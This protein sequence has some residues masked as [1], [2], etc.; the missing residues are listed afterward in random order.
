[1]EKR[2]ALINIIKR[3]KSTIDKY[4]MLKSGD[5]VVVGVS[6][7]PDS[8]CLL[9]I[10]TELKTELQIELIAAHFE[11][12]LRPGED[13]KETEFVRSFV[14]SLGVPFE[15]E[16]ADKN[17]KDG[18]GSLEEK[19]R[20]VRYRFL[21]RVRNKYDATKIALG[22]NKNDQAE[23]IIMRLLRG[24]GLEGL[25]GIPPVRDGVI[26]RPIIGLTR[27]EILYY[28]NEKGLH[29]VSD[30]SNMDITFLRNRI[31]H[32]L[33]PLLR[34]YQPNIIEVL[35]KTAEILFV[36]NDFLNSEAEKWV[37]QNSRTVEGA[38]LTNITAFNK[39]H[40]ALKNRILKY[41]IKKKLGHTKRITYEHISRIRELIEKGA[42]NSELHLPYGLVAKK[43]Y[44]LLVFDEKKEMNDY[45]YLITECGRHY[46]PAI[47]SWVIVEKLEPSSTTI[48]ENSQNSILLDA[49]QVQLPLV[50]R[51][52]RQGDKIA[53]EIGHKKIKDIFIDMKIPKEARKG[54]PILIHQGEPIHVWCVNKTNRRFKPKGDS[55]R[56]LRIS[57][58]PKKIPLWKYLY[59]KHK[60]AS[61]VA[62]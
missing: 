14:K 9:S 40:P 57:L 35:A 53:L 18:K 50:I 26:I 48:N 23:T 1:M 52:I 60:E 30:P 19:A 61:Y 37:R 20:I 28:L 59:T 32:E 15:Y 51:N 41:L 4:K 8:V 12:G 46:L 38:I 62:G 31:R 22:H 56:I 13:E 49:D 47:N 45:F 25:K 7:G 10:L 42:P 5:R 36:E 16:K 2:L 58:E 27:D 33:I 55:K 34:T 21:E 29:Y 3:V 11:H 24:S 54:I 6:G 17:I 44:D 43:R 39:T